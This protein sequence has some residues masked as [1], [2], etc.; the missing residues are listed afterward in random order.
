MFRRLL[1]LLALI[2]GFGMLAV[3]IW[4]L[5]PLAI[6]ENLKHVGLGFLALVALGLLQTLFDQWAWFIAIAHPV[7]FAKVFWVSLAGAAV[8][9]LTP[10]GEGG[11]V[12]KVNLL[13]DHCPSQKVVSAV[14]VWNLVYR[15]TKHALIFLGPLLLWT[16]GPTQF[17]LDVLFLFLL[18]GVVASIPTGLYLLLLVKGCASWTVRLIQRAPL[19]GR[20]IKPSTLAKAMDTDA[21]VHSFFGERRRD[22]LMM[23]ALMS[24]AKVLSVL[25]FYMVMYL[26]GAP[27]ALTEAFFLV[28]GISVV[29]IFVSVAPVQIGFGEG[30]ETALFA[31]LGLPPEVGFSQAFV[32]LARSLLFN[33][34]GLSYLALASIRGGGQR[35]R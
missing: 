27:V 30:G 10:L 18:A 19:L 16:I 20:V 5:G 31:M 21:V 34:V 7:S 11:E 32:R 9:A 1:N 24:I 22:A 26:I 35:G 6:F 29:R 25:E 13:L 33:I 15:L 2:A 23:V 17:G 12:I 14:L 4:Q 8:S 28:A 3:L